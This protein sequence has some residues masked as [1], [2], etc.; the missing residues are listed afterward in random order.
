[1]A[2][3]EL[4]GNCSRLGLGWRVA[5]AWLGRG[6]GSAHL[7][8]GASLVASAAIGSHLPPVTY[9]LGVARWS[10]TCAEDPAREG[11]NMPNP[12]SFQPMQDGFA[13]TNKWPSEPAVVLP[14]PF[15]NI[16]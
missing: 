7:T 16:D 15:G 4:A 11:G 9:L 3:L 5:L 12:G 1:M 10:G 13:F 2:R 8:G 14:T 6:P